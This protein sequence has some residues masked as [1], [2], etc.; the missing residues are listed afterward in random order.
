MER[1]IIKQALDG[2]DV[3]IGVNMIK[4]L[5]SIYKKNAI[6]FGRHVHFSRKTS[7]SF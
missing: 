6:L 1:E 5:L 4:I 3:I 2:S 7:V